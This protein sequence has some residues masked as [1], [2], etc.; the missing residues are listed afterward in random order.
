MEHS[1]RLWRGD[2]N[3]PPGG[4]RRRNQISHNPGHR[5][6]VRNNGTGDPVVSLNK[7]EKVIE[8]EEKLRNEYEKQ[9][10]SKTAEIES[11][12]ATLDAAKRTTREFAREG[13]IPRNL[14]SGYLENIYN[15]GELGIGLNPKAKVTGNILE[16]EKVIGTV[17]VAVGNNLSF[18][19][20]NDVPLHLDG[21]VSE[22]TID[23]D[24]RTLMDRGRFTS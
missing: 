1:L 21:V 11:L 18:G 15:L 13:K 3:K 4:S 22:P 19:G 20:D 7:L 17:H 5:G 6:I 8:L 9:L 12:K 16:D 24:G 14:L 2:G 23:I 10:N